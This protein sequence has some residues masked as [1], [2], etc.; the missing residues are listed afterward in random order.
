MDLTVGTF[1]RSVKMGLKTR[2][3][4]VV[5]ATSNFAG[6]LVLA[7]PFRQAVGLA[8]LSAL[9]MNYPKLP[10]SD[11]F[12]DS[13]FS[14]VYEALEKQRRQEK[15]ALAKER[16]MQEAQLTIKRRFGKNAILKGLNF[17]DGATAK[18]RN[19]QIGGHKA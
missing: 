17:E 4:P 8:V 3:K 6:S 10:R 11:Q 16:R 1:P 15:E 14:D 9:G 12:T 19:A 13:Q 2:E 18:E 5:N 7:A